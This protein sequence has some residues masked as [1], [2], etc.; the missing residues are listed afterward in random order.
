MHRAVSSIVLAVPGLVALLLAA[1]SARPDPQSRGIVEATEFRLVSASGKTMA[2]LGVRSDGQPE[3]RF[4]DATG[5]RIR[6]GLEAT[7]EGG[8]AGLE[9][10]IA[11]R[12][13]ARF[14]TS[15]STG[16]VLGFYSGM[17]A[18]LGKMTGGLV[19]DKFGL[20]PQLVCPTRH[21]AETRFRVRFEEAAATLR[22]LSALSG[23]KWQ[24]TVVMEPENEKW[25]WY[26]WAG[27]RLPRLEWDEADG[28]RQMESMPIPASTTGR[29]RV[30]TKL[31]NVTVVGRPTGYVVEITPYKA[32]APAGTGGPFHIP[33]LPKWGDAQPLTREEARDV[34]NRAILDFNA[35]AAMKKRNGWV[36]LYWMY[37]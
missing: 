34:L 35:D 17:T 24:S 23:R 29:Y 18:T 14:G 16:G 30:G 31:A 7:S 10:S 6:L 21:H 36:I 37:L 25:H 19:T 12:R 3:L 13:V 5:T 27:G 20:S 28:K 26:E 22:E 8:E 9:F 32:L 11:G 2:V 33:R 4:D 15:D 1:V